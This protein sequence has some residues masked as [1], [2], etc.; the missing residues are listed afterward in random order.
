MRCV[1]A[2]GKRWTPLQGSGV[3][4]QKSRL[5]IN[6]A[7]SGIRKEGASTPRVAPLVPSLPLSTGIPSATL[8]HSDVA[9]P[10]VTAVPS[11]ATAVAAAPAS[12][13]VLLNSAS[14]SI[15]LPTAAQQLP[16]LAPVGLNMIPRLD[17]I[18]GPVSRRAPHLAG[19]RVKIFCSHASRG[20]KSSPSLTHASGQD[21][22]A[23]RVKRRLEA[24]NQMI[25]RCECADTAITK[26]A[27]IPPTAQDAAKHLPLAFPVP[28]STV[29]RVA[30]HLGIAP[31]PQLQPVSHGSSPR[32]LSPSQQLPATSAAASQLP[33]DRQLLHEVTTSQ[34]LQLAASQ[35]DESDLI[36]Q[37]PGSAPMLL[38]DSTAVLM[39]LTSAAAPTSSA[40]PS[41]FPQGWPTGSTNTDADALR[42]AETQH[43]V[44]HSRHVSPR[45][46]SSSPSGSLL[47]LSTSRQ[48][49]PSSASLAELVP[50]TTAV[51]VPPYSVI[52]AAKA[53]SVQAL[54]APVVMADDA[55]MLT[56]DAQEGRAVGRGA[57]LAVRLGLRGQ[58][59][60]GVP[61]TPDQENLVLNRERS[62]LS[63]DQA[64][65]LRHND[66]MH[67]DDMGMDTKRPLSASGMIDLAMSDAPPG[68]IEPEMFAFL[69]DNDAFEGQKLDVTSRL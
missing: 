47:G 38:D 24:V 41:S 32:H 28:A 1:V 54:Y 61:D 16:S 20:I 34:S 14:T 13:P 30:A 57:G 63:K 22:N 31:S 25:W 51:T 35:P 12:A 21:A 52:S 33:A 44:P 60:F 26:G 49:S 36:H 11:I 46:P 42:T 39:S 3:E 10:A 55:V 8:L 9:S 5:G 37:L 29:S 17:R 4:R 27:P 64:D 48:A 18:V 65:A 66:Y 58:A 40:P 53:S 2:S 23:R 68:E 59:S 19:T 56:S 67:D 7:K 50:S 15:R 69:L 62:S 43:A 45:P 6:R